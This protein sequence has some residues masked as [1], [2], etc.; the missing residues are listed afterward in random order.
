VPAVDAIEDAVSAKVVRGAGLKGLESFAG[1]YRDLVGRMGMG[2][3]ALLLRE[4]VDTTGFERA[5]KAE[6]DGE[7]RM[8]NVRELI[9]SAAGWWDVGKYLEEKA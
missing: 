3:V 9:A 4:I 8:N 2:D 1:V 5:L 6:V 7:D